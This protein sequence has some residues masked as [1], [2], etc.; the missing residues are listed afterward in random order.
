M[1]K[2]SNWI[3][4]EL[5]AKGWT[6]A[7]LARRSGLSTGRLSSAIN[8]QT[9]MGP[10]F[11]KAIARAFSVPAEIIFRQ[12]GLLPPL[13]SNEDDLARQIYDVAKNSSREG[14]ELMLKLALGIYEQERSAHEFN[15]ETGM[16]SADETSKSHGL[17]ATRKKK[18]VPRSSEA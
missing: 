10:D 17:S 8:Y 4:R 16:A 18:S 11:C 1:N 7:E 14:R 9:G 13:Q 12:A 2:L 5:E 15:K 3:T 6:Q